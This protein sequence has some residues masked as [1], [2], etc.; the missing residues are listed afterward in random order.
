MPCLSA[1]YETLDENRVWSLIS[2]WTSAS[3]PTLAEL[4]TALKRRSLPKAVIFRKGKFL[5]PRALTKLEASKRAI[6]QGPPWRQPEVL[7][8][9]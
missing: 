2:R 6:C 7:H 5:P 3:D 8:R 9:L 1:V 4:S